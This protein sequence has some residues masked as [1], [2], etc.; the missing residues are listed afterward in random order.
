M[1]GKPGDKFSYK[2][3]L[4]VHLDGAVRIETVLDISKTKNRPLISTAEDGTETVIQDL[5]SLE[6]VIVQKKPSSLPEFL[7]IFNVFMPV[8]AG[9]KEAVSRIAYEFCEDCA[10]SGTRYVEVRY[11]PHLLANTHEKP[12][13]ARERGTFSPRDVVQTVCEALEKGSRDCNVTVNSILCCMTHRPEWSAEILELCK[14]FKDRGVVAIDSAGK[15]FDPGKDPSECEH[16]KAFKEAYNCGIHRTVHAGENGPAQGVQEA[17][18]HMFA[19][20]IGHGYHVIDDPSLYSRC[21]DDQVHFEMCPDS[22]IKTGSCPPDIHQHPMIRFAKEGLNFS[23]NTDDPSI[24]DNVLA[25]DYDLA[26]EMGL[27]REQIIKSIFSA[28]R[29]SFAT[30]DQKKKLLADLVEVYGE[31]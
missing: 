1:S 5:E 14:E 26:L 18:D 16:K 13:Y 30:E 31:H 7:Q 22:S 24:L 27:S 28:A 8:I 21:K 2:V 3:E 29:A 15:D 20:R 12:D 10:S 25:D 4:H 19:E 11:C 23:I 9:D 17:L 6:K